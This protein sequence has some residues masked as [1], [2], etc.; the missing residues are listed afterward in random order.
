[1]SQTT[2]VRD[3]ALI[4]NDDKE[5]IAATLLTIG[6]PEVPPPPDNTEPRRIRREFA[7]SEA[8]HAG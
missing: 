4:R 8:R 2:I 5:Q 3:L 1:V 6:E 7:A